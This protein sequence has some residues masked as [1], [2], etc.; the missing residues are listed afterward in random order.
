VVHYT[1]T[2]G[3]PGIIEI[4][5]I[6]FAHY[7][8]A[9]SLAKPI[10]SLHAAANITNKLH[11]SNCSAHTHLA[12]HYVTSDGLKRPIQGLVCGWFGDDTNPHVSAYCG[13]GNRAWWNGVCILH[14]ADAGNYDLE[15]VSTARL[16]SLYGE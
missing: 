6:L 2:P 10:N 3:T 4:Q 15:W 13:L 1:G 7:F 14:G 16:R 8:V 12:S 11:R 9:G 5:G